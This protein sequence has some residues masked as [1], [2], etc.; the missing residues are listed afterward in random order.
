MKTRPKIIAAR[1]APEAPGL[2]AIPSHA[3]DATFAC[4]SAPPNAASAIPNAADIA[5]QFVPAYAGA[6]VVC[7]NAAGLAI[8]IVASAPT[9]YITFLIVFSFQMYRQAVVAGSSHCNRPH[10]EAALRM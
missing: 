10:F 6:A 1:I 5:T 9:E 7:A 3:D 8:K 2:R 4:A